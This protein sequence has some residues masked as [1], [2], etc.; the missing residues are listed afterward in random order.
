MVPQTTRNKFKPQ[1][2]IQV[3]EDESQELD[4]QL[5]V[6][7]SISHAPA[8]Q[9][10]DAIEEDSF[11]EQRAGTGPSLAEELEFVDDCE[12]KPLNKK[13]PKKPLVRL[14]SVSDL[15]IEVQELD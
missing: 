4:S 7:L 2:Q 5:K 11:P 3:E 10:M 14:V 12:P 9:T 13:K 6:D 8:D 1:L 15:T